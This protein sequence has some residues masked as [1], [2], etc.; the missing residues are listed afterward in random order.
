MIDTRRFDQVAATWDDDPKR[1]SLANAVADTIV[2]QVGLAAAMD[3]L[4]FGCGTGLLTLALRPNVRSVTGADTSTGMLSVLE[5]KA[6]EQ[7]L[8]LVT[9]WLL[10]PDDSYAFPGDYDLIVSSMTLHHVASL[11]PLFAQFRDHLRPGG[12]VALADLD[13]EDGTFHRPDVTDV[14]HLGFDRADLKALL[15]QAG[16]DDLADATAFVHHRNDRDYPV[17]LISGRVRG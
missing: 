15:A 10:R 14:F 2:R 1:V 6:R 17:F 7:A 4:D 16:F 8:K 12:R 9:T 3:V 5:R 13:R 11:A